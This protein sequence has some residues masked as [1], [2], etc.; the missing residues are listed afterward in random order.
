MVERLH[1]TG[2]EQSR[3]NAEQ[4]VRATGGAITGGTEHSSLGAGDWRYQTTGW[5]PTCTHDATPVPATVLDCFGGS[6]TTA[7][8]AQHL[9]RRAVLIE[10]NPDYIGQQLRRNAAVPLGLEATA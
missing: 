10:L 4:R 3:R 5:R 1:E 7:M 9:G 6:G 2:G 8:V